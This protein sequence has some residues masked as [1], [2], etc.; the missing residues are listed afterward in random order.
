MHTNISMGNTFIDKI[1]ID[2]HGVAYS[3]LWLTC[4][5]YIFSLKCWV[6]STNA[7]IACQ[8]IGSCYYLIVLTF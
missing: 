1:T 4:K 6:K 7:N 3:M 5:N 2:V 8:L